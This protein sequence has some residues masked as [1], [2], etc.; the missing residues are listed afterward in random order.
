MTELFRCRVERK[1]LREANRVA[2]EIG[3]SP[4]EIVRMVFTQLVKR[5]QLPFTAQA[6]DD[7][8]DTRRRNRIWGELDDAKGW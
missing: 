1:L 7:L 3:T 8:V 2:E 4:G 6:D 5:R